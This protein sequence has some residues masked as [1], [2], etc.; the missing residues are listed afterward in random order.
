MGNCIFG[1]KLDG[2]VRQKNIGEK[3]LH[4][5]DKQKP[6]HVVEK[7]LHV[8]QRDVAPSFSDFIKYNHQAMTEDCIRVMFIGQDF[9]TPDLKLLRQ[10]YL[11]L[12]SGVYVHKQVIN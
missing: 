6:L 2:Y 10:Q 9:K 1:R 3:P 8:E 11:N 7:Q 12:P 5:V 4:V